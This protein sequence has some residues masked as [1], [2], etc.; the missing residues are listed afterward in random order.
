[1]DPN[2]TA[3]K[4][5]SQRLSF[6]TAGKDQAGIARDLAAGKD[7]PEVYYLSDAG[8]FDEFFYFLDE[9]G[10]MPR[11]LDLDPD[12]SKRPTTIR[13]PAVILI[14][15]M[16]I[17]AGLAFFWHIE[18]VVLHS[19][20]LMRLVGFN[21]REIREGTSRRGS[22]KPAEQPSQETEDPAPAMEPGSTIRG[23]VCA[24]S[25]ATYIQAIAAS[26]LERLFNTVVTV[27]AARAFFP[28]HVHA[29]LDAS[30][31]Q[32]TE[33]CE[34]RGMVSKEKPPTLRLRKGRIKKVMERVFGF[35]IWVVWDPASGLPLALRFATIETADVTLAKEVVMQARANL[36]AHARLASVAFDRGF[37]DGA[38]WWWLH[39]ENILFY[40]PAK[41]NMAVYKDALACVETGRRQTRRKTRRVGHGKN[42]SNVVDRWEVVG[43]SGLT[44]AG[45]YGEKGSGSHENAA[46]FV[47]NPINAAVVMDDPFRQNNPHCDTM[48]ILTN[49]P[50]DKPLTA[51]DHYDLRSYMENS[52]FRE[53]KQAWFIERPAKNTARAFR[54]HVYLTLIT[55][56]LTT[57]F[58]T[59]LETQDKKERA[60]GNAGIR[61]F[62]QQVRQECGNK[63][64]VFDEGR[65]AIFEVYELVILCGRG[66]IRPRGVPEV[67]TP[68]D[69]LHKYGAILE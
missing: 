19:Q 3:S 21:A 18:P 67:I 47:A 56:A 13:F 38:F 63:V 59:W 15:L 61:A 55:M 36:G 53:A 8:L 10:V 30:E 4:N 64:I 29:T 11:L 37:T 45:F 57:A 66:V 65:Y 52:L 33:R 23:P 22:K 6:Q 46:S 32:S 14:Y 31:I 60:G 69:I 25:I 20:A 50:V 58:R 24:D 54:A 2:S 40:V 48:V 39:Q 28:K 26:A 35:K 5:I 27:L 1:M 16:R 34:G 68:T 12:L 43:I 49:A 42:S 17:V 7:V 9:V 44:S 51:Y 62:C 41:T